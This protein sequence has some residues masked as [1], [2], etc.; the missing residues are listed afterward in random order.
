MGLKNRFLRFWQDPVWSKVI[1]TAIIAGLS[2]LFITLFDRFASSIAFPKPVILAL[3][4][5]GC[6][7]G[8]YLVIRRGH[9]PRTKIL[10]YVSSGGTCR[11]P[12]AKAI[13][14][15]LLEKRK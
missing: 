3:L 13:T 14:A 4:V 15:K 7:F 1:A 10:V 9:T 5:G 8:L 6:C 12:M 11:D 2:L